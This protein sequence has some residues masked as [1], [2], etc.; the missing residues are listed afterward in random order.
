MKDFRIIKI[1]PEEKSLV[2]GFGAAYKMGVDGKLI[3]KTISHN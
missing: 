1:T 3:N 2:L